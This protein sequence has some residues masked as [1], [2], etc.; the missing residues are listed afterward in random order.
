MSENRPDRRV[1]IEAGSASA[2]RSAPRIRRVKNKTHAVAPSPF[3]RIGGPLGQFCRHGCRHNSS[4]LKEAHA[5]VTI[6]RHLRRT[7][8]AARRMRAPIGTG[9]GGWGPLPNS[10]RTSDA[11][12]S[13][14]T[15]ML[16][17]F[18]S[19][20][21]VRFT[22]NFDLVR[23]SIAVRAS[24]VRVG[25]GLGV[26]AGCSLSRA[27]SAAGFDP[28]ASVHSVPQPRFTLTARKEGKSDE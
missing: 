25:R 1:G 9:A 28:L 22:T 21:T 14:V 6:F 16:G 8:A 20:E 3:C 23:M 12:S 18:V 24:C 26:S 5:R 4:I 10:R 27:A 7:A 2:S 17:C 19:P 11:S 15:G 13:A